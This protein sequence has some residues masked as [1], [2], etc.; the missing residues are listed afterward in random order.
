MEVKDAI[1]LIFRLLEEGMKNLFKLLAILLPLAGKLLAWIAK[2]LSGSGRN[3]PTEQQQQPISG[4]NIHVT[5]G[6]NDR[7][8]IH[9]RRRGRK[10]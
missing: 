1:R 6:P 2:M 3:Q 5:A 4:R 10:H 9:R 7:V 8:R